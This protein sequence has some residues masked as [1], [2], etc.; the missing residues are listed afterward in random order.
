[1]TVLVMGVEDVPSTAHSG[2]KL[3]Q[4]LRLCFSAISVYWNEVLG[5]H[6][7]LHNI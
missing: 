4:M 6:L 1:M 3:Y 2:K 5:G 7:Q